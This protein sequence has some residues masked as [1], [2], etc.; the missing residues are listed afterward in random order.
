MSFANQVAIITG[1]SS[2]IGWEL[3]KELA[4]RGCAVGLVA[5]RRERLEALAADCQALGGKAAFIPADVTERGQIV[6]AIHGL[7]N[8]L[9]PVDLLIANSGVSAPTKIA[10]LNIDEVDQMFRVNIL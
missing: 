10:P 9:G 4:R 3:A 7:G 6:A 8:Q 1:A 2:G 5:R